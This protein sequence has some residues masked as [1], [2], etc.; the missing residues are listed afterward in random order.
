MDVAIAGGHGKI[1]LRLG[2]LLAARGDRVRGLVR[3]PAQ[4]DDLRE[5]GMEPVV[6]DLEQADAAEVAQ[7]VDGADAVVFAAGAGPGSGAA[8]KTTMD[9]GGATLLADAAKA[10]GVRRYVMVS[11]MRADASAQDDGGFG[12]YLRAK[13]LADDAVR[14]SGL[15]WTVVRP[16]GLADDEGHGLVAVGASLPSGQ[17]SRDDVAQVLVAVLDDGRT[18]GHSFDLTSGDTPVAQALAG[19]VDGA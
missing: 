8:R 6:C 19:L 10:A 18:V 2:R 4:G 7:A 14:A 13:G 5:R 1:A 9:L 12:T 15:D 16:G 17:V 11:A 3:D